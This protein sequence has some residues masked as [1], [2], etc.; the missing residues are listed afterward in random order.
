MSALFDNAVAAWAAVL[1]V[2]LPLLILV[3]GELEER[4][5]QRGSVLTDAVRN[6]RTWTLGLMT[7]WV[8]VVLVFGLSADSVVARVVATAAVVSFTGVILQVADAGVQLAKRRSELPGARGIPQLLLL[9]PRIVVL[10]VAAWFLFAGVWNVDLT[11]AFAAL[12]VTSLVISLALQPT[13]SSLASGLLLVSDRPFSPGDWIDFD[14]I[15]GRVID[16]SWRTT[17][18]EDRNGDILVIPNSSLSNA[19]LTNFA[20]PTTLHRVVVPVQVA[21]SNPPTSA[22]EMLLAAARGTEGVLEDP[23]PD[24]RVVQIDDP[25]MGY[26]AHL[27]IDDYAIAPRVFS[28]FGSLVWYQ[29][30]R[31]GVPLPSPAYDLYHHDPIQEAADAEVGEEELRHRIAMSPLL[32][33]LPEADLVL[34]SRSARAVRYAR[35]ET[36]VE[37]RS[38]DRHLYVLWDGRARIVNMDDPAR[39]VELSAGD[40]FTALDAVPHGDGRYDVIAVT[41]CEVVIVDPEA[42][43]S[44]GSRNSEL[45][46]TL[47]RINMS[48]VKRLEPGDRA[49][50]FTPDL[51]GLAP[52]FEEPATPDGDEGVSGR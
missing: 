37:D 8:L 13:L 43:G 24:I 15:E 41:D 7:L 48:R 29:S 2:V 46:A 36:I 31:M 30:F 1:I 3:G 6:L 32:R 47:S 4:L 34:A 40:A 26:V 5:R 38:G 45:A 12:G 23:P 28:D 50:D 51:L 9:L 39:Y 20:L 42:G 10:L 21:F 16:L 18:I 44:I 14:G 22:K 33:D 25:L 19:T 49:Y 27:W 52:P 35:S 17:R 11:G